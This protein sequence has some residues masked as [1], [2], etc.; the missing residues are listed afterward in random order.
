MVNPELTMVYRNQTVTVTVTVTSASDISTW[1]VQADLRT[2]GGTTA[3]ATKTIGS[4]ITSAYAG[5]VQT[6]VITFTTTDLGQTAGGYVYDF[7]RVD[8]G[9]EYQII[10]PSGFI[11]AND[12]VSGSATITNLSEYKAYSLANATLTDNMA[13]QLTQ[14]LMAAEKRVQRYCD[15]LFVPA[16]YTEYPVLY[17]D[18]PIM[19]RETPVQS[20]TSFYLDYGANDG[21]SSNAFPAE[22][23]QTVG[24]DYF[25]DR[26]RVTD[27]YSDSGFIYRANNGLGG[28]WSGGGQSSWAA[29]YVR[30]AGLLSWNRQPL[31][32]A[33]K[34]TYVAGF[35]LIPYDLKMVVWNTANIMR[36]YAPTGRLLQGWSGEGLSLS[37]GP[38]ADNAL[39]TY[40]TNESMIE[41]FRR[42][43]SRIG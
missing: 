34:I 43:S 2:T 28:M 32:G 38:I 27:N 10:D 42:G 36:Q 19:L 18:S 9:A 12:A 15:R 4:G 13:L 16:T 5:G 35:T 41:T 7:R 8:V 30:P 6:W 14:I 17:W 39:R 21:Q 11:I 1:L 20:I 37:Y 33:A 24:T 25:L 29:G 31:K 23:L 22:T 3:I 26:D 40:W